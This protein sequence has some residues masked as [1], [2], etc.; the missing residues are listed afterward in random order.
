MFGSFEDGHFK[1][2]DGGKVGGKVQA[3]GRF[4]IYMPIMFCQIYWVVMAY[5][6]AYTKNLDIFDTL[7]IPC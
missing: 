5:N 4:R 6:I 7:R 2:D 1:H 3:L